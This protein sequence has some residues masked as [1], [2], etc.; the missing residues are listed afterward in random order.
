MAMGDDIDCWVLAGTSCAM[1]L[2]PRADGLPLWRHFGARL[3]DA[4]AW[5]L[6]G[7]RPQPPNALDGD[8]ALDVLPTEGF[9]WFAH[10]ALRG[11]R[12][13]D[14]AGDGTDWAQRFTLAG[15]QH[16][17]HALQ[18]QLLD[19]VCALAVVLHYAID[20]ASDVLTT[21]AEIEN[22]GASDFRVDWLAAACVP[23]P[24]DAERVIGFAGRWTL[25]FQQSRERLGV[26][27]WRRD[28]RRGRN[29]HE[30]LP[31]VIVG[32]TLAD[33][34]GATWGAHL[35][36]SGNHTLFIEALTDGR[37]QLQLGEL[38]A[39]GEVVLAP[40][41]RYRTPEA[42][43]GFSAAGLNGLAANFHRHVRQSVLRWPGGRMAPRPVIL[44]TWEAVYFDQDVD[45]LKAL[46]SAAADI[47]IERFVLDDGWFQGRDDDRTSLGDWWPDER[48]YPQGLSPLVDHVRGLGMQFGLWVEPEMVNPASRLFR[49]HPDWALQMADRPMVLGR[50]QLLLDLSRAEV[51]EHLFVCIDRLLRSHPIAY[52]KWDMN[53]DLATAATGAGHR[54]RAA[55]RRHTLAL[56][57]LLARL[58]EAHPSVEIESCSSGGG[59]ADMGI[60]R[61]TH[62][63][64]TSDCNDA[65]ARIGIQSGFLRFL[66]PEVM[67]A[68]IG[69]AHA[70]TTG[71]RHSRAFRASV[72][73]FGHLGVEADV[74]KLD[75]AERSELAAWIATY[76]EWR[77]VVHGGTLRQ[78]AAGGLTWFQ[79]TAPDASAALVGLYRRF[80]EAPRYTPA[81]HVPGL[82]PSRRYRAKLLHRPVVPHS[83]STTDLIDRLL[84]GTLTLTG[85]QLR[86]IGLPLP[87]LPPEEALVVGLRA[88]Q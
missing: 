14:A 9:G 20:P 18:L 40:G 33:D 54:G 78:G 88:E 84:A 36:W 30:S 13:G 46:A 47:G 16:E 51:T 68:H 71:R 41:E 72:A 63:V 11:S 21:W 31:A 37:R 44:N 59:R 19:E 77:D 64:W 57:T 85:A 61:H 25:E 2:E 81:L 7:A 56:Y 43:L 74:R 73:L 83:T 82:D 29:G 32:T 42:H 22:R 65:L 15:V 26:A 35:A 24:P 50:N 23:L 5:P 28:S 67:G 66:P 69:P 52:L 39:P 1:A 27:T 60:L 80:E 34:D 79:S 12:V 70:H 62:R 55:Y 45:G 4:A 58:R 53:R 8:P 48:K 10:P 76:K 6:A 86:D 38:L 17:A 87:P 49:E 75:P 3:G